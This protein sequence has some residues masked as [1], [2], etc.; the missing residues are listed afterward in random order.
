MASIQVAGLTCT[1]TPKPNRRTSPSA[2]AAVTSVT[3]TCSLSLQNSHGIDNVFLSRRLNLS[4]AQNPYAHWAL[5]RNGGN[6]WVLSEAALRRS[7][8]WFCV[9]PER[10]SVE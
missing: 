1:G 4:H 7:C 6:T 9:W 10:A 2:S 5:Y 3:S 8:V